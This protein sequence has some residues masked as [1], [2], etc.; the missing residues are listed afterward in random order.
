[1]SWRECVLNFQLR[2]PVWQRITLLTP[3]LT[4]LRSSCNPRGSFFVCSVRIGDSCMKNRHLDSR[5]GTRAE[6]DEVALRRRRLSPDRT[7]ART[8]AVTRAL[9]ALERCRRRAG[10]RGAA[11]F[12]SVVLLPPE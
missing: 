3:F 2:V 8:H 12:R 10:G 5:T 1:M 6:T 11:M 4:S 9:L 7:G